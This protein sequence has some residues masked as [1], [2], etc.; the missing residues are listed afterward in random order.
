MLTVQWGSRIRH[1]VRRQFDAITFHQN[2][3]GCKT[4]MATCKTQVPCKPHPSQV[5]LWR[6]VFWSN[7]L[8]VIWRSSSRHSTYMNMLRPPTSRSIHIEHDQDPMI[9]SCMHH[10]GA[11]TLFFALQLK[12]QTGLDS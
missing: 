10:C 12:E 1:P 8:C 2:G 5:T 11:T 4:N 9:L 3:A 7:C 6:V